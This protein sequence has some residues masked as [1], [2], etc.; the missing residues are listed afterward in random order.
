MHYEAADIRP[1]DH[2]QINR[3]FEMDKYEFLRHWESYSGLRLIGDKRMRF[4]GECELILYLDDD[5]LDMSLKVA[6]QKHNFDLKYI[7][8]VGLH[9]RQY[10]NRVQYETVEGDGVSTRESAPVDR[11]RSFLTV[12]PGGKST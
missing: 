8:T 12:I 4:L 3:G 6:A 1:S 5:I 2:R 10:L 11:D 7:E 9:L